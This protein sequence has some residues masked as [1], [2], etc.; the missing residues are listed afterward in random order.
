MRKVRK[1]RTKRF[2]ALCLAF[3]MSA[4]M[5]VPV[6]ADY[7]TVVPAQ[8]LAPGELGVLW[9]MQTCPII[10]GLTLDS[11]FNP[12]GAPIGEGSPLLVSGDPTFVT[13]VPNPAD[14]VD[15]SLQVT[16]RGA[17][18]HGIQIRY[19]DLAALGMDLYA[20]TYAISFTGRRTAPLGTG[21]AVI[22][23]RGNNPPWANLVASPSIA[24]TEGAAFT[25]NWT[26]S[27]AALR[28]QGGGPFRD[29]RLQS[30]H[31]TTGFTID[32]I[33]IERTAVL[34]ATFNLSVDG[35][36]A[37]GA[38]TGITIALSRPLQDGQDPLV[39]A[40]ITLNA[41]ATNATAESL[42]Q[43]SP[44]EYVLGI[45]GNI[46]RGNVS[47]AIAHPDIVTGAVTT[48]LHDDRLTF[49]IF[50]DGLNGVNTTTAITLA[51]PAAVT[52]PLTLAD[53]TFNPGAT[54]AV[55]SALVPPAA[56]SY[57]Y[58]LQLSGITRFGAVT[59]S[60]NHDNIVSEAL[61][62]LISY[63]N[64]DDRP[65]APIRPY[66]PWVGDADFS[67]QLPLTPYFNDPFTFFWDSVGA[68]RPA[69]RYVN[70]ANPAFV[71]GSNIPEIYDEETS[72]MVPNPNYITRNPANPGYIPRYLRVFVEYPADGRVTTPEHWELRREEVR[73]L[74]MYYVYGYVWPTTADNVT[75]NF[76]DAQL[77]TAAGAS[78]TAA[79]NITG[80]NITVNDN[81][82][83]GS[84]TSATFNAT[85]FNL[86]SW[87][88]LYD[89]GFWNGPAQHY[90]GTGGPVLA[91]SFGGQSI[92]LLHERGIGTFTAPS[93]GFAQYLTLFP[94]DPS[95]TQYANGLL[96]RQAWSVSRIID[97]AQLHPEL[98][99]NYNAFATTGSSIG[100]KNAMAP[101]VFDHR[102]AVTAPHESGGDGGVAPFRLNHTG[103]I[104]YYHHDTLDMQSTNRV[105]GP[106]EIPRTGPSGDGTNVR[107]ARGPMGAW[108]RSNQPYTTSTYRIPVDTHLAIAMGA[109]TLANPN[110]AFLSLETSNF[111]TWTGWSPATTAAAAAR[112]V[113]QFLGADN[114]VYITKN[115]NHSSSGP[116]FMAYLAIVDYLF[117]QPVHG[118]DGNQFRGGR[119]A[120]QVY[121]ESLVLGGGGAA[122]ARPATYPG[123]WNGLSYLTR[124]PVEVDSFMIPWARPGVHAVWT[125]TVHVTEGFPATIVA[126]TSA[127]DGS[128]MNL[129]LRDQ[130][131]RNRLRSVRMGILPTEIDR[132]TATVSNGQATFNLSADDIRLGRYELVVEGVQSNSAYF[133]GIDTHTA[134]RSGV[135]RDAV[136]DGVQIG[137]TS[138][139]VNTENLRLHTSN[140]AGEISAQLPAQTWQQDGQNWIT[141][142]GVRFG[143]PVAGVGAQRAFIL[144]GLE[145]EALPGIT[146]EMAFQASFYGTGNS[147]QMPSIWQASPAAARVGSYPYFRPAGNS[148]DWGNASGEPMTS[149]A[150]RA[151][152]FPY[153]P[154][155]FIHELNGN[156]W[157]ITFP[158]AI[159]IRD[160]GIGFNVPD[161]SLAWS[162]GNT[163]L[164]VTFNS[165]SLQTGDVVEMYINRIRSGA[166]TGGEINGS[167]AAAIATQNA[168]FN[169]YIHQTLVFTPYVGISIDQSSGDD[170]TDLAVLGRA[171][172]QFTVTA[173]TSSGVSVRWSSSNNDVATVS[174]TGLVTAISSGTV[175]ITARIYYNDT[176]TS[177]F[178]TITVN[179][180]NCAHGC[181]CRN[182]RSRCTCT[183]PVGVA[184]FT[185]LGLS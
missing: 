95:V 20:H 114:L 174:P 90:G 104:H 17:D 163:V 165:L 45:G 98:G 62:V 25:V 71:H 35:G 170:E 124:T 84:P 29:F 10:Q 63:E 184:A 66:F 97:I 37:D 46:N 87:Q 32:T 13:A 139:V 91:G 18:W 105:H 137:F 81:R 85:G 126:N 171:F 130:G 80:I 178:D 61:S 7:Q 119:T 1:H 144:R 38:T 50:A 134:M 49:T 156:T 128:T 181:R 120:N 11:T 133:Q 74:L 40:D 106:H 52:P 172:G 145:M 27:P 89:N 180:R 169:T 146:F 118:A 73:D 79:R 75:V 36:G 168:W 100:G 16:G 28:E 140:A 70:V 160:F 115:S 22:Q 127:P 12:G 158:G 111:G 183:Q 150:L 78:P 53:I 108:L 19:A 96:A 21:G 47:V 143:S 121:V 167:G 83:D 176:P 166:A 99:I 68:A 162:E 94:F 9:A 117:G 43:I 132:W 57:F 185:C 113:F 161:F 41:M 6:F 157:T 31:A 148:P 155:D 55:V 30:A 142:Y 173:D 116:D 59:V 182:D 159:N 39:L 88:Q 23:L 93:G 109:P 67:S 2:L 175:Q 65:N 179:V 151:T 76:T 101:G 122:A 82:A 164:T 34:P 177:F 24:A 107:Y 110:R 26:I 86:P 72:T 102:V 4:S 44:T 112:E 51:L 15:I 135:T 64:H 136:R 152:T 92:A 141:P 69:G 14:D 154:A 3:I 147:G 129:I 54:G 125:N 5:F 42:T 60:I 153:N 131:D 77:A 8:G 48:S 123:I 149:P 103:R 33:T 138:R 58:Q 56:G